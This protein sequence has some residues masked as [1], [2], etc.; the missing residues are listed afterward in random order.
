MGFWCH[1]CAEIRASRN[2]L[3]RAARRTAHIKVTLAFGSWVHVLVEACSARYHGHHLESMRMVL[4]RRIRAT[5]LA[6]TFAAWFEH[7]QSATAKRT[8]EGRLSDLEWKIAKISLR[9]GLS[10]AFATWYG[11][12]GDR[13]VRNLVLAKVVARRRHKCV[14]TALALWRMLA[15]KWRRG[16]RTMTAAVRR[17]TRL[18]TSRGWSCWMAYIVKAKSARAYDQRKLVV[19]KN[20]VKRMSIRAVSLALCRWCS[21]A[22]DARAEQSQQQRRLEIKRRCVQ[23]IIV[24]SL[25]ASLNCWIDYVAHARTARRKTFEFLARWH[26]K[27]I[28][29]SF[30]V[31]HDFVCHMATSKTKR[32]H[33]PAKI[34]RNFLCICRQALASAFLSWEQVCY[35]SS[36]NKYQLIKIEAAVQRLM[37]GSLVACIHEWLEYVAANRRTRFLVSRHL[38]RVMNKAVCAAFHCW[39]VTCHEERN[40]RKDRVAE[41][42]NTRIVEKVMKRMLNNRMMAGFC[43]W[44]TYMFDARYLRYISAKSSKLAARVILA[45]LSASFEVWRGRV[46]QQLLKLEV[47]AKLLK[48]PLREAFLLWHET[49]VDSIRQQILILRIVV[50]VQLRLAAWTIGSWFQHVAASKRLRIA[51]RRLVLRMR[52]AGM[53]AA[54]Q[55]WRGNAAEKKAI[56]AKTT[57]VVSRWKLQA[58]VRCLK[59]WRELTAE[60]V[61]KR[62]LMG[63]IVGRMLHRSL[64]FCCHRSIAMDLWQQNVSAA[65]QERAE[66]E[67]RQNIVSRVVRSM[68]NQAQAAALERWTTN[69]R[70]LARQRE[71]MDRILRRILK[72]KVAA[73]QTVVGVLGACPCAPWAFARAC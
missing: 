29:V 41:E 61:R 11:K 8:E 48:R 69:V 26:Q 56:V 3:R 7:L 1:F 68:L 59:A 24:Q 14:A 37:H 47:V 65:R 66:E 32:H 53:F 62:D 55:R 17:F 58:V 44:E 19:T 45:H 52:N 4:V 28:S 73:G 25:L 5:S 9:R 51:G 20:L 57:R 13:K 16:R 71:I 60:E 67:Q 23:R 72:A 12:A 39:L 2:M 49:V 10:N 42:R 54:F 15:F 35:T 70:E 6:S 34:S 18:A 21:F 33:L 63:R 27:D 30:F 22:S 50:R 36:C 46:C 43:S 31:W 40:D 38:S 64:S